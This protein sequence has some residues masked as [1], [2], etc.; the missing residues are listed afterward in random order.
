MPTLLFPLL[1]WGSKLR[2]TRVSSELV[3]LPA[4]AEASAPVPVH[5]GR[6]TPDSLGAEPGETFH[7]VPEAR[8]LDFYDTTNGVVSATKTADRARPRE[9]TRPMRAA[10]GKRDE[11]LAGRSYPVVAAI[12]LGAG[13]LSQPPRSLRFPPVIGR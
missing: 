4:T 13:P 6:E 11:R 8:S 2:Q 7:K 10:C 9:R 3:S 5:G 1:I 12:R